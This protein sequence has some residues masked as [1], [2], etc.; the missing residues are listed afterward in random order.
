MGRFKNETGEMYHIILVVLETASGLKQGVWMARMLDWFKKQGV[1]SGW[2]FKDNDGQ[3]V[4]ATDYDYEFCRRLAEIQMTKKE[5]IH[6]E[7]DV[8]DV[9]SL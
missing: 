4:H 2:V 7:V 9:Y 5:L 6:V 3:Q 1:S 8:F